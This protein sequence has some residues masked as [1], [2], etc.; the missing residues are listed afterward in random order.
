MT[1]GRAR[2]AAGRRLCCQG[3]EMDDAEID[4]AV[5]LDQPGLRIRPRCSGSP[6]VVKLMAAD[7]R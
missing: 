1:G 3:L 2:P 5:E 4:G 6:R 7:V